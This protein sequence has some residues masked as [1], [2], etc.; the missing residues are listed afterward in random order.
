MTISPIVCAVARHVVHVLVD[1]PQLARRHVRH[2]LPR[3]EAG[4]LIVG[5]RVPLRQPLA[6]GERPVRLGETV[7]VH[8][9]RPEALHR[10]DDRRRGRSAAGADGQL[11]RQL[12]G[13]ELLVVGEHDEDGRRAAHVGDVVTTN[14]V[15]DRHRIDLAQADVRRADRGDRPRERPAVAVEHRQRPQID[16][17]CL[18]PE[19][20]RPSPA[21][22]DT[23]RGACTSRP[24][25]SRS[26]RSCS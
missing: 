26:C 9:L 11:A 2:S 20:D 3:L 10:A 7:D 1:D 12:E 23:R 18:E 8:E 13:A 15:G 6:G 16:A 14:R 19:L 17:A 5:Q 24:S 22:S 25:E 21:R 4:A